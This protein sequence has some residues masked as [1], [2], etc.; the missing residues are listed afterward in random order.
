MDWALSRPALGGRVDNNKT[1]CHSIFEM[2]SQLARILVWSFPAAAVF[3]VLVPVVARRVDRRFELTWPLPWVSPFPAVFLIAGGALL[4][5]W[6]VYLFARIGRGTP[7]PMAPPERL[8]SRGPYRYS[9]NPMMLGGWMLGIGLALAM[10][11]TALLIALALIIGAGAV[12]VRAIEEP[13]LRKRFG[14]AYADY[15][16]TVPRWVRLC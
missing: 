13:R 5:L 2:R 6:S 4:A 3:L 15:S 12:Y 11:S 10:R 8:V 14:T 7:N 16:R 9:R 1:T